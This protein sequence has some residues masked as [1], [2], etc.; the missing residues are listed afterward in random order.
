MVVAPARELNTAAPPP[1]KRIG[2]LDGIRGFC[3]MAV[4]VT[5]VAFST[6]V[7]SSAAGPPPQGFWSI[8]AAGQTS[9]IGPFFLLSG[10]LLYRP[11]ARAT[12]QGRQKSSL[13]KFF[14]RRAARL[15]PAFWLLTAVSLALLNYDAIGSAWDVLRPFALMHVYDQ[16]YYAGLDVAW[17]VPAEIQFYL[18][19]PVVAWIMH[20]LAKGVADPVRK[21][22]RM[23]IPLVVLVAAQFAWVFYIYGVLD[24]W[25]PEFFYPFSVTGLFALGMAI[26]VWQVVSEVAPDRQPGILRAAARHP[27]LFWLGALGTYVISCTQ[28]FATPGTADWL[29]PEAGLV[30]TTM[31]ILFTVFATLPLVMPDMRSRLVE[32]VLSNRVMRFLGRIS[33]GIYLWHFFVMYLVFQSGAIF[34]ETAPVGLL[35]GKFG[36]WEL[37]VP[38]LLG[39]IAIAALSH[40]LYEKPITDFIERKTATRAVTP[41]VPVQRRQPV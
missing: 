3:A 28:P 17:T 4:V 15:L 25:P 38:T 31:L 37:L 9:A 14:V 26:A 27:N 8:L 10:L 5:H 19:L 35:L 24:P 22:R 20:R 6:I 29:S 41:V 2:R 34:G 16:H 32:A 21:A 30:R 18:A 36:F 23:M 1:S 13:G 33:Y 12:L 40:Y 39:T 7:L 11:F